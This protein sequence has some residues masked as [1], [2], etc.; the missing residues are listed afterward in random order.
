MQMCEL[1]AAAR[2]RAYAPYSKHPVGVT[3]RSA[4]GQLF[5]GCNVE[6][7]ASPLGQCAEASAIGAM[8]LAGEQTITDV[9]V[10]GPG[11]R[12]C[13]PCG[14]CR[15]RLWEFATADTQVHLCVNGTIERQFPLSDLLPEAFGHQPQS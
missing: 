8:I 4:S 2:E 12:V 1:A 7:I 9:V 13:M 14:G 6:N 10:T 3:L 11:A 15:Q 5:S